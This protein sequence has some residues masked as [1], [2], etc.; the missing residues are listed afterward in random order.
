[1]AWVLSIAARAR[2]IL[3]RMS[4]GFAV[5]RSGFGSAFQLSAHSSIV[6][7]R[8]SIELNE[9]LVSCRDA[10]SPKHRSMRLVHDAEVEVKRR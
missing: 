1:M 2:S 5:Q 4:S 9:V 6:F 7:I 3:A 10:S 8:W